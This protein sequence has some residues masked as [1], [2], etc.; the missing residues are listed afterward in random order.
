[1]KL[2]EFLRSK[3]EEIVKKFRFNIVKK[4]VGYSEVTN[5]M[6]TVSF[7]EIEVVDFDKLMEQIEEF[8]NSFK[9]EGE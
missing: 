2:S 5:W 7:D 9:K 8:E 1:M 3:K 4:R 6:T